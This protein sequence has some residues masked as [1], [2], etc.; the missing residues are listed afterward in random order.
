MRCLLLAG[1]DLSLFELKHLQKAIKDRRVHFFLDSFERIYRNED[2]V[3][4]LS[5]V[6][7]KTANAEKVIN[8]LK[9]NI[10]NVIVKDIMIG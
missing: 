5:E 6:N 1:N 9:Q 7:I 2:N 3:L 10:K 8:K 4:F